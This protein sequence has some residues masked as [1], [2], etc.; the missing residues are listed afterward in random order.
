MEAVLPYLVSGPYPPEPCLPGTVAVESVNSLAAPAL[1]RSSSSP[2]TP[3]RLPVPTL[4]RGSIPWHMSSAGAARPQTVLAPS[5]LPRSFL[6]LPSLSHD[7]SLMAFAGSAISSRHQA[8][9]SP[10]MELH[11]PPDPVPQGPIRPFQ[12]PPDRQ[13][14]RRSP[15]VLLSPLPSPC[16]CFFR[17]GR[18]MPAYARLVCLRVDRAIASSGCPI[19]KHYA[20]PRSAKPDLGPPSHAGLVHTTV[21]RGLLPLHRPSGHAGERPPANPRA[22]ALLNMSRPLFRP[23]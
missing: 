18:R 14:F 23:V 5:R 8:A 22:R 16:L 12:P 3:S 20:W 2:E 7:L 17:T 15:A 1:P 9:A 21:P 13:A 19:S 4:R 10:P 11:H 6:S